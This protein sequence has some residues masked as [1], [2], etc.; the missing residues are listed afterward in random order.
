LFS[1]GLV[2]RAIMFRLWLLEWEKKRA[3]NRAHAVE[4]EGVYLKEGVS[5]LVGNESQPPTSMAAISPETL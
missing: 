2:S 1:T 3:L 5:L 4:K